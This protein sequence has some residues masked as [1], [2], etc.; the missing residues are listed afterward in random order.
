MAKHPEDITSVDE[1]WA[2]IIWQA[3]DIATRA[4]YPSIADC[5]VGLYGYDARHTE[6]TP[7]EFVVHKATLAEAD[8]HFYR[9][10]NEA[11]TERQRDRV[12]EDW[13]AATAYSARLVGA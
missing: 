13:E 10:I 1:Y 9:L 2:G 6:L 7:A 12:V 11:E 8:A 4:G 3:T 5:A